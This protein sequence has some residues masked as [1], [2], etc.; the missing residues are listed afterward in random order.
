[1]K[2]K[3]G[4]P[5]CDEGLGWVDL[6]DPRRGR[7]DRSRMGKHHPRDPEEFGSPVTAAD[8]AATLALIEK[9]KR[10]RVRKIG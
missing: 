1:M 9:Q 4:P 10:R 7:I 5:Q 8:I 2:E 6:N 3:S